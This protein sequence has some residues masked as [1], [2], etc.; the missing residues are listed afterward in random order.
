MDFHNTMSDG[1]T[2]VCRAHCFLTDAWS[3]V[4][5]ETEEMG[6]PEWFPV[7]R[8]PFDEMLPAERD[9]LPLVFGGAK[10]TGRVYLGPFQKEKLRDTE[11]SVVDA[12]NE[13]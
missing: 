2:F 10:V 4:P 11:V 8:V 12:F 1:S 7:N 6:P 13:E 9:W 5:R 3:G